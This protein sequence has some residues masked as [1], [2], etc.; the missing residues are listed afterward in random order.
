MKVREI[1]EHFLSRA[2]WVDRTKTV[3]R[4]IVGDPEKEVSRC[5][6]AWMPSFA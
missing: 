6:V 5:L 1:L 2:P 3:D 4:V